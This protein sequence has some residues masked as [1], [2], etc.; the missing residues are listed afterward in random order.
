MVPEGPRVPTFVTTYHWLVRPLAFLDDC[1]RRYGD[2]FSFRIAG[3]PPLAVFADPETVKD[4]F[5]DAGENMFAGRFNQSLRAFLGDHSVLM[6]DG[7]EHLRHRR[8]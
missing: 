1:A 7:K 3:L 4:I 2:A 8:L 5:A 6:L